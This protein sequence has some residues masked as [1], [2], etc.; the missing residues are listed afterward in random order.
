MALSVSVRKK[1]QRGFALSAEFTSA[2]RVTALF[3]RSGAGKT[4]LVNLIA[5]LL[6]PSEGS[7]MIGGIYDTIPRKSN[8]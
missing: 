7:V 6:T 5:G 3:G 8:V 2:G 1:L 4:T